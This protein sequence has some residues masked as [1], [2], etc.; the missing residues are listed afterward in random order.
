MGSGEVI[1]NTARLLATGVGAAAITSGVFAPLGLF[2]TI[3]VSIAA[4]LLFLGL[5]LLKIAV[6][7]STILVFVGM[8]LAIV[9]WP[10]AP[11]VARLAGRAFIVC[12]AVPVLWALC[13][14]VSGAVGV[15]A[16]AF[17]G[18]GAIDK[19]VQPLVAIVLLWITI[20]LPIT[21]AR[22]A[23]LGAEALGGGF[24]SRAVSYA[25]GS[26]LR[27]TIRQ[28]VGASKPTGASSE[29][30]ASD[31]RTAGRLRSAATLAGAAA[32]AGATGG[33]STAAASAGLGAT[34]RR[35]GDRHRK[36][37]AVRRAV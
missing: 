36:P 7:V 24:V 12:L 8:P 25:A 11:W 10:A 15:D 4:G 17:T 27:D 26:Q 2:L 16:L 14:A 19:L 34:P 28:H 20:K 35:R 9:L 6:S 29:S 18:G 37:A 3:A 22:A 32:A 1:A 30:A 13:F 31:S 33:A 23:M 21:L 5:L